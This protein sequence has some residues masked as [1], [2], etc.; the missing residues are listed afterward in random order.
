MP[1][2]RLT[3]IAAY[4]AIGAVLACSD[5]VAPVAPRP[6]N[7][8]SEAPAKGGK[9]KPSNTQNGAQVH[10]VKVLR[11]LGAGLKQNISAYAYIGK[12]GGKI[13]LAD[14]GVTFTVPAGALSTTTKITITAVAG[15]Y[16]VFA[17]S[18][19]GTHFATP[20]IVTVDLTKTNALK[21]KTAAKLLVGGYIPSVS[22]IGSDDTANDTEDYP[23]TTNEAVTTA[24]F[25]V[26]HFSVVILASQVRCPSCNTI[27]PPAQ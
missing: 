24:S 23:V 9:D 12:E 15:H 14:L 2:R 7:A 20:A 10:H 1:A 18:P 4:V 6:M 25:P 13:T 16:V 8:L 27:A 21:N 3:A 17:G 19:T 22:V 26:P 5:S 11:W